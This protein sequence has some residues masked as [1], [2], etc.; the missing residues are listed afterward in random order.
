YLNSNEMAFTGPAAGTRSKV[1]ALTQHQVHCSCIGETHEETCITL[2]NSDNKSKRKNRKNPPTQD[3]SVE[4]PEQQTSPQNL[5]ESLFS[6]HPSTN[7]SDEEYDD[8]EDDEDYV[9]TK[10]SQI[11]H[12]SDLPDP[13]PVRERHLKNY[14]DS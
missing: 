2:K 6:S 13:P 14:R 1:V 11:V 8:D 7:N 12:G 9:P 5:V 10:Q 3:K 4:Q